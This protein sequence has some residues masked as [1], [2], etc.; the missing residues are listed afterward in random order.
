[1]RKSAV[2]PAGDITLLKK[3]MLRWA[4]SISPC[5]FIDHN[6]YRHFHPDIECLLAAGALASI[7]PRN[8]SVFPTLQSF[9][10]EQ[11]DW[12]FGYLSY[13]LKNETAPDAVPVNPSLTDHTG[14][15]E[16]HFFRPQHLLQITRDEIIVETTGNPIELFAR[17]NN[18]SVHEPAPA[19]CT[20]KNRVSKP[21][22]LADVMNLQQHILNGDLYEINLCQE[23]YIE[24]YTTDPVSLFERL[25]R[26]NPAPFATFLRHDD[27]YLLSASPERFL[28]KTGNRIIS[29][30]MKGTR[31]RN[32]PESDE[33]QREQLRSDPK[34]RAENVMIVDLVRNDLAK[35]ALPGSV[36]VDE[37]FG[38]FTFPT[39]HQMVST[40]SAE[41]HPNVHLVTSIKNAFP[42]GSMTGAP[43]IKAMELI[44]QYEKTR[45]GLFSGTIGFITPSG[46]FDF[47][48]V[49]RSMLYD[50]RSAYLSFEAG[51]AITYDS[52]PEKEYEECL[53]KAKALMAVLQ[54]GFF[55]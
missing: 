15:P 18:I 13:E 21:S 30:P 28:K 10:D 38:V 23:F 31:L 35:S 19:V 33:A 32:A 3:K 39:V 26:V 17:I 7:T 47:S 12:L 45:R 36:Q 14:F 16:A 34:E 20:I 25:N 37:L 29:Q 52:I 41:L 48:V 51:S 54:P 43:K 2:F 50:A 6:N 42:M 40:V 4:E 22:Y 1:M 8:G 5:V 49:I 24:N 44:E 46:D 27:R 55:N 53:L 9:Y 11:Q